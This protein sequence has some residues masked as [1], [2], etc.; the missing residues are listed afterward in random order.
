[1]NKIYIVPIA[2]RNSQDLGQYFNL[3]SLQCHVFLDDWTLQS[4]HL[5]I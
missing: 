5:S 3:F 4:I 1:M 2:N